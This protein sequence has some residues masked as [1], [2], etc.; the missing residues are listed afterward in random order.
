MNEYDILLLNTDLFYTCSLDTTGL[1]N[2]VAYKLRPNLAAI[3]QH[4]WRSMAICL[5]NCNYSESVQQVT[6]EYISC[7]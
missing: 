5:Y 6:S 2:L 4:A 3:L 1:H 7:Y